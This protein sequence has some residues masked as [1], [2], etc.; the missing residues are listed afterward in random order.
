MRL[1][2]FFASSGQDLAAMSSPEKI[3]QDEYKNDDEEEA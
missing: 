2:L 1:P 3:E